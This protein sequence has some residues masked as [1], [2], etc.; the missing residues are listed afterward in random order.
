MIIRLE[1]AATAVTYSFISILINFIMRIHVKTLI[2]PTTLINKQ[3][4][5]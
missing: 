5:L 1:I 4:E 3:I 2:I